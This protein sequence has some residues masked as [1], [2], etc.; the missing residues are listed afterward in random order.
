MVKDVIKETVYETI[1][2]KPAKIEKLLEETNE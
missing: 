2:P 1:L